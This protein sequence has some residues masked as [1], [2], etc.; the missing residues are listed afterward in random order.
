MQPLVSV[1]IPAYN[2]EKYIAET[3]GYVKAQTVQNFEIIIIDDCS[4]D[5]TFEI[6]Q[7]LASED[8]RITAIKCEKNMGVARVRNK[9]LSMAKGKYVALL[10]ADDIWYEDKLERQIK[11]AEETN[12]DLVYCSYALV[13]ENR[14][15][16]CDDFIVPETTDFEKT[17]I[18]SVISCSTALFTAEL[19]KKY[20]FPLNL[21]H[22]DF[23]LWLDI[24]KDGNKAVGD[25][26]VTAEYRLLS[27]SRSAGKLKCAVHRWKIYRGYLKLPLFKSIKVMYGY[28]AEG[29][30]KYKKV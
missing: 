10:D 17:L 9:G 27:N 24:L 11:L 4:T 21:Y 16:T 23:A 26:K 22:E 5:K 19:C 25:T 1:V 14:N 28:A 13:D 8:N 18:K 15:K 12:A 30:R 7:K 2:A 20:A 29:F 6:I 3:V